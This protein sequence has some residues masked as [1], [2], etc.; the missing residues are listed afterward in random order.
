VQSW[1]S[2]AG[3]PPLL[4][5]RRDDGFELRAG[6]ALRLASGGPSCRL[7]G[8]GQPSVAVQHLADVAQVSGESLSRIRIRAVQAFGARQL[9]DLREPVLGG[10][11]DQGLPG[12]EMPVHGA[13]INTGGREKILGMA[14]T[15]A[16]SSSTSPVSG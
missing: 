12:R 13:D 3:G 6:L 11:L 1:L 5:Q 7:D 8:R 9:Q 16:A 14:D 10:G 2:V 15:A 4:D